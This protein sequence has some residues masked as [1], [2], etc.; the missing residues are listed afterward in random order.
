MATLAER[1]AAWVS[2]PE[3]QKACQETAENTAK[4]IEQFRREMIVTREQMS[5]PVDR[6]V[7]D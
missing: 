2:S 5:R 4:A 6:I 1:I 7:W 3:G